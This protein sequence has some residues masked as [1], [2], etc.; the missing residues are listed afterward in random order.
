MPYLLDTNAA[1]AIVNHPSSPVGRRARFEHPGEVAISAIV[2][3][4][5][6]YG[7]FRSSRPRH[8]VDVVD[9]L[10]FP[11]IEFDRNDARQAGTLRAI[12][13]AEGRPIGPYDVLIAGQAL[14]RGMT[15]VTD[16]L[17]EFSRIRDLRIED[18]H[19]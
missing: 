2:A 14:A 10:R 11:I 19:V 3:H 4:E 1:I 13:A 16:N 17:R 15:L 7:S 5:L 12:L 8:N 9:A 6:Y 18:W